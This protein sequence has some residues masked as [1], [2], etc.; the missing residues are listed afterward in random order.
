MT[1]ARWI[2]RYE[3]LRAPWKYDLDDICDIASE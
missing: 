2:R 3:V 1:A